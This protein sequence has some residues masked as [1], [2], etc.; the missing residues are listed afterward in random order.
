MGARPIRRGE[1]GVWRSS[2]RFASG[3]NEAQPSQENQR[4]LTEKP[5][6]ILLANIRWNFLW[7][8]SQI[9][10][11][12][13]AEAGY[14]TVCVETTGLTHVRPR[15]FAVREVLKRLQNRG[16]RS[17]KALAL[18]EGLTVYSPI[19]LPP[20]NGIF[21]RLNRSVFA[22]KAGRDLRELVASDPIVIAMPPNQTTLDLVAE[23]RPRLLWYHCVLNYE[24]L[25]GAPLDVRETERRL[26]ESAD[27]VSVDSGFL[28]NKHRGVR[29]DLTR[30]QSGVNFDLFRQARTD[31]VGSR[32][33]TVCFYGHM[34]DTRFD[35]D[36]VRSIARAGYRVRLLGTL[37][38]PA[39]ARFPNVEY[40]G[41]V[42]HAALPA[43]LK[44]VDALIMPYEVNDFSK[45]TFPAK[46]YECLATGKPVVATALPDLFELGEHVYLA[47]DPQEFVETLRRLP[48]LETPQ[49]VRARIEL[50]RQN[51][52]ESRFEKFE[53]IL[54]REL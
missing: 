7:Q 41:V 20:T 17:G 6:V 43:H 37:L 21:R 14:P 28:E 26:L 2:A 35:F 22:A 11:G 54:W 50:A 12:M 27:V 23:V 13:F 53:E 42:P 4:S 38:R 34:D 24:D 45:G 32:V 10:A 33:R 5:S 25:P 9:L 15:A 49:K 31:T 39:L 36:L 30:I 52:W 46:T 18:Q 1:G 29:P 19:T 40:R 16:V 51:S 3:A 48:E 8:W 44:D 47:Q